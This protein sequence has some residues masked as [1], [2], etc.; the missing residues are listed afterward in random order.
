[1]FVNLPSPSVTGDPRLFGR[2]SAV[3]AAAVIATWAVILAL[4]PDPFRPGT[5]LV[6]V[7]VPVAAAVLAVPVMLA[8]DR[9]SRAGRAEDRP[10]G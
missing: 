8:L 10:R 3:L 5:V 6:G 7:L 4:A 9:P 1:M 2:L